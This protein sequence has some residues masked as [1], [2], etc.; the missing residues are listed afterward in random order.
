MFTQGG[1][2][3]MHVKKGDTV[4]VIAGKDKGKQGR[5]LKLTRKRAVCLLKELT[6]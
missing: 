2:K 4:I 1:A 5:S 3:V 6:W